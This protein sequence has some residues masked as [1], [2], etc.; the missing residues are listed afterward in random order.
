MSGDETV[1]HPAGQCGFMDS[2]P[3]GRFR[4]RQHSPVSQPVVTRT[5]TVLKSK[6]GHSQVSESRVGLA[7]TRGTARAYPFFVQDVGDLRIDMIVEELIDE[8]D[9]VRLGLH[10]LR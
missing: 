5:E 10:L 3:R 2:E 8:F 6:I 9:D 7:T 4:L 1:R